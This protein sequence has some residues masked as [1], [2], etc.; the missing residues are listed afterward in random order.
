[1]RV[2]RHIYGSCIQFRRLIL[3][4]ILTTFLQDILSSFY[5]RLHRKLRL[6]NRDATLI[7]A[8]H[9]SYNRIA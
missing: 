6:V 5:L 7:E 1:M 2:D 8:L 9:K 3:A 4:Q